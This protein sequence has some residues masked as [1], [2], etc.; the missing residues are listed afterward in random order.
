MHHLTP[1]LKI[2]LCSS[3]YR[4]K[5][6]Q[7]APFTVLVFKIVP[8][9][10]HRFKYHQNAPF[11]DPNFRISFHTKHHS[12]LLSQN[13]V[14]MHALVSLLSK[15]IAVSNIVQRSECT[16]LSPCFPN[17]LSWTYIIFLIAVSIIV[18]NSDK[19]HIWVPLFSNVSLSLILYLHV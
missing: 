4:I 14:K 5:R 2:F 1:F 7:N 3:R 15:T 19:V 16:L 13:S 17:N 11:S 8:A 9:V 12:L 10:T 6:C 18:S